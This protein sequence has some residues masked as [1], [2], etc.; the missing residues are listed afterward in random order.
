MCLLA[1][2]RCSDRGDS[3][4]PSL[5]H[6]P[7]S[8]TSP[9][10]T[11][12]GE[13][14]FHRHSL[15]QPFLPSS[16]DPCQDLLLPTCNPSS[17]INTAN[18]KSNAPLRRRAR[19]ASWA[20]PPK[21]TKSLETLSVPPGSKA[22]SF[23]NT[24]PSPVPSPVLFDALGQPH[25]HR[26]TI[27]PTDRLHQSTKSR[28]PSVDLGLA[29][30]HLP[31]FPRLPILSAEDSRLL[32]NE[33]GTD[34]PP[35]PPHS[36]SNGSHP[37]ALSFADT[38]P[39]SAASAASAP[40]TRREHMSRHCLRCGAEWVFSFPQLDN[41]SRQAKTL[42]DLENGTEVLQMQI[43]KW[44]QQSQSDYQNWASH[45]QVVPDDESA[46]G[47]CTPSV[48]ERTDSS[49]GNSKRKSENFL[50]DVQVPP[51]Q[52]RLN[53]DSSPPPKLCETTPPPDY[54]QIRLIT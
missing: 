10:T 30:S 21:T 8:T 39:P 17:P 32:D 45:H 12:D 49:S 35:P 15:P 44:G 38:I 29:K 23:P 34:M 27:T 43:R 37:V 25:Q 6:L 26:P 47:T 13:P 54:Y 42:S 48:A 11:K 20:E 52:R 33:S 18:P 3:S 2:Y 1:D 16:S 41:E 24:P 40:S 4:A 31:S 7:G 53:F 36:A 50:A 51:K 19:S 22:G 5:F 28:P 14:Q 46:P 9:S